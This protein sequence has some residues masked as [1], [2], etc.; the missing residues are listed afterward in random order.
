ML[1]IYINN[2]NNGKKVN[3]KKVNIRE[4]IRDKIFLGDFS[5]HKYET[6]LILKFIYFYVF[7]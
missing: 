7:I 1:P 4:M 2:V 5:C 6:C 3:G